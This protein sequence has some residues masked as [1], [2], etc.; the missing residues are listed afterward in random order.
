MMSQ[1]VCNLC[2]F[3]GT[4]VDSV[5]HVCNLCGFRATCVDSVEHV[6]NLCGFRAT[7]VQFV[8]IPCNMQ[9]VWIPW[10]MCG[11]RGFRVQVA[12]KNPDATGHHLNLG[13]TTSGTVASSPSVIFGCEC[14]A[15]RFLK[16]SGRRINNAARFRR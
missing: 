13:Y 15:L 6:C 4:C 16:R 9:F 7:C 5:E 10:N 11:F 3:R 14:H 2:G 8:W 12:K 1:D